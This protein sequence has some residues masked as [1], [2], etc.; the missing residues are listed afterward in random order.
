MR[1][2]KLVT[3]R[4]IDSLNPIEGADAIE[5]ATVGGWKVV[6]KRGEFQVGDLALYLEVDSFLPESDERFAFLMKSGVREF[7]GVRGHKLRTIK[8]RGQLSQGLLLPVSLFEVELW[9]KDL[10]GDLADAIGIKKWEPAISP[11]LAGQI[12]GAFPSFIRKTDQERCVHANTRVSTEIGRITIAE[13]LSMSP[14]PRAVSMNHFT[15]QLELKSIVGESIL[16]SGGNWLRITTK[17]GRSMMVTDNHRVWSETL[18]QYVPAGR[19]HVGD[20]LRVD[21]VDEES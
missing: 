18:G 6:V 13:L 5:V 9:G 12:K 8:L 17:S 20:K 14:R 21:E 10:A 11:Q 3:V 4:K 15:G 19:L 2:R 7:E 16:E 1:E